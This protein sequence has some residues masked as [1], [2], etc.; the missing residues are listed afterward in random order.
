M[1]EVENEEVDLSLKQ[2]VFN[3]KFPGISWMK[4]YKVIKSDKSWKAFLLNMK[5]PA[6]P[7]VDWKAL[8]RLCD[9]MGV[10]MDD[11]TRKVIDWVKE[12]ARIGCEGRFQ[13]A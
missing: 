2:K 5:C 9:A 6:S 4:C 10:G 12:G 7:G 3:A 13:A 1:Q 11:N 8:K